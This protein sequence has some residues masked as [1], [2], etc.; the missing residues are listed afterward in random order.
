MPVHEA[1]LQLAAERMVTLWRNRRAVVTELAPKKISQPFD[2]RAA[3]QPVFP[4]AHANNFVKCP[5]L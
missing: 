1:I 2:M 3:I 4:A 5:K